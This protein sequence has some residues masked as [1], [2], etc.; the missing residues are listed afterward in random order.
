M[1]QPSLHWAL[2]ILCFIEKML[3]AC[4]PCCRYS[5]C[6]LT[7]VLSTLLRTDR[8]CDSVNPVLEMSSPQYLLKVSCTPQVVFGWAGKLSTVLESLR[9]LF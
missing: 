7:S 9:T 5:A 2:V 6:L 8:Y 4:L 1:D 3:D